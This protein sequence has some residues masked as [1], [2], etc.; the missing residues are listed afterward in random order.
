M[1]RS[2]DVFSKPIYKGNIYSI[3]YSERVSLTSDNSFMT[4]EVYIGQYYNLT[5]NYPGQ[6]SHIKWP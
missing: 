4:R 1:N 5:M 3:G 2:Q 6:H